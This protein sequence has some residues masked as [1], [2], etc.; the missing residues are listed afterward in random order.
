[1]EDGVCRAGFGREGGRGIGGVL[2]APGAGG[3]G[4]RA[5]GGSG[6]GVSAG[7]CR[8]ERRALGGDVERRPG[9]MPRER[10]R[11]GLLSAPL[12]RLVGRVNGGPSGGDAGVVDQSETS[13]GRPPTPKVPA[14]VAGRIGPCSGDGRGV[15]GRSARDVSRLAEARADGGLRA[16]AWASRRLRGEFVAGDFAHHRKAR[17]PERHVDATRVFAR[18]PPLTFLSRPN[19]APDTSDFKLCV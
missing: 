13:V 9:P 3:G 5:C 7:S 1:M 17:E 8:A 12:A 2:G 16:P 18:V 14:V 19:A 11:L 4:A 15:G 6:W 10:R